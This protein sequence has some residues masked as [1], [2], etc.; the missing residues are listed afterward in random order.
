MI[1]TNNGAIILENIGNYDEVCVTTVLNIQFDPG[2]RKFSHTREDKDIVKEYIGEQGH[3]TQ[4]KITVNTDD[5]CY[6][7]LSIFTYADFTCIQTNNI[8]DLNARD[9]VI[10]YA[11][12]NIKNIHTYYTYCNHFLNIDMNNKCYSDDYTKHIRISFIMTKIFV[13]G[14]YLSYMLKYLQIRDIL[15]YSTHLSNMLISHNGIVVQMCYC[16]NRDYFA[17]NTELLRHIYFIKYCNIYINEY[18]NI[19][20][21]IYKTT[22]Q[23]REDHIYIIKV[24]SFTIDGLQIKLDCTSY[25]QIK[26]IIELYKIYYDTKVL[27]LP[28]NFNKQLELNGHVVRLDIMWVD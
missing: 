5:K 11:Y 15:F 18:I 26:Y 8:I 21:S 24:N 19:S 23:E 25:R 22:Q 3:S 6:Y 12:K 10:S 27:Y 9:S 4:I 1:K 28:S 20:C 2:N 14:K 16:Y 13:N 17:L 7:N